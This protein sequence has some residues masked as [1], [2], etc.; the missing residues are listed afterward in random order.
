M[1]KTTSGK[2]NRLAQ[3][4]SPYLLQHK[5]NPVDW[6]PWGEAAW[7]KAVREDKPIF[8]SIGYSTCHW[9][10][11]MER[12]SFED[13]GVA[14]ILNVGF[15]SVKLDREE[16]PDIDKIYM[17][18][19]QS[20]FGQ[21]G[22]PLNVFLTSDF[23]PFYGGTYFPPQSRYGRPSFKE[24]LTRIATLWKDQRE[25]LIE[26][27]EHLTGQL[28]SAL[29]IEPDR[30]QALTLKTI[31]QAAQRFK[32]EYDPQHG[33]FGSAPKFPRPTHPAFL[34][35]YAWRFQ[36]EEA[37]RMVLQTCKKWHREE[38]TIRSAAAFAGTPLMRNGK[39]R[40]SKKCSTIMR[41]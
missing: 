3:E 11:V 10:H 8:L 23:K 34:I 15:V 36:D 16:R 5:D 1:E 41:N 28:K 9:C 32:A 13:P 21:G 24:L 12:E 29:E 35:R 4:K 33:G 19:V 26:G 31:H 7:E 25:E 37:G 17:T 6:Y 30:G 20:A 14:E 27:A 39:S 18:A 2:S 38:S 22:W 40:T